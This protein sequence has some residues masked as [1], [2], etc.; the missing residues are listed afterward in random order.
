ML[1]GRSDGVPERNLHM[2]SRGFG[3]DPDSPSAAFCRN[4]MIP[5]VDRWRS[6]MSLGER[7]LP[8]FNEAIQNVPRGS[9][10][11]VGVPFDENCSFMRG[12][13]EAPGSLRDALHSRS[14]NMCA[15]TGLDLSVESRWRD[16][17]DIPLHTGNDA[18]GRIE[19][20]IVALLEREVR[21]VTLGGDHS[22]TLPILRAYGQAYPDLNVLHLDAHPDLY[23][24]LD[25]NRYSHGCPFARI[26]EEGLVRRLVQ[27]GVRASTPHQREQAERFG[28]EV[29]E[30]RDWSPGL[31]LSFDGPLYVTLDM[32]C[33]DPAF[34]PGVSHYEP[35]GFNVREL[36]GI[37][38]SLPVAPVG[39]DLVELNPR[40]DEE[41][42]TAA[43]GAKL[44]KELIARM[45]N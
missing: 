23:D 28:V 33:L 24:Q 14:T 22:I 8:D 31:S 6:P 5:H 11:M 9:I 15:E 7:P 39:A 21:V 41:G 17:G 13:V 38:H 45:L 30:A 18:F 3:L 35:G 25:G 10:A 19:R 12:P 26:M 40:R 32:D 43:V 20:A 4:L 42:L 29:I 36:L 37:L 1:R 16:I 34:A 2:K 44:L 27:V